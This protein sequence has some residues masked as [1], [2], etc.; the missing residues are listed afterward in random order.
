MGEM[1]MRGGEID[2]RRTVA[3]PVSNATRL[4]GADG[5]AVVELCSVGVHALLTIGHN[6]L[7][8]GNI[9]RDIG[10]GPWPAAGGL[11]TYGERIEYSRGRMG[12]TLTIPVLRCFG[13]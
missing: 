7:G 11:K 4:A 8:F 5:R 13:A 6:G 1:R 10:L 2:L 12:G 9:R 3:N